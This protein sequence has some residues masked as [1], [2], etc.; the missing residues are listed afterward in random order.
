MSKD[1]FISNIYDPTRPDADEKFINENYGERAEGVVALTK[2]K[3]PLKSF[4]IHGP[5]QPPPPK[6]HALRYVRKWLETKTI[7]DPRSPAKSSISVQELK[8]LGYVGVYYNEYKEKEESQ[9]E[10]N[11][12][13]GRPYPQTVR[14][15]PDGKVISL[16]TEP[17]NALSTGNL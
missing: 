9:A 10:I 4:S 13:V 11:P 5:V 17:L 12:L 14:I 3:K 16:D 15:L 2:A 8:D 6:E 1:S 7:G